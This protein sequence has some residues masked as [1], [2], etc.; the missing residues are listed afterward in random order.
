MG[1]ALLAILAYGAWEAHPLL[2]GPSLVI[3]S[4][5][6][7]T[8]SPDGVISIEGSESRATALTLDGAPLLPD[9]AGHFSAV[10]A[11]PAGGSILTFTATDRFGRSITKTRTIYVPYAYARP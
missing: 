1:L 6:D 2:A 7:G 11:F 3:S 4:P 9:E 8:S 5:A 10:L